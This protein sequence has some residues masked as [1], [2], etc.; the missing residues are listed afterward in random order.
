MQV[1]DGAGSGLRAARAV[2]QLEAAA[3]EVVATGA[4]SRPYDKTTVFYQ[5]GHREAAQPGAGHC[6]DQQP[7]GG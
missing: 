3:Y 4:T 7:D 6:P 1:L 5:Q 2:Q